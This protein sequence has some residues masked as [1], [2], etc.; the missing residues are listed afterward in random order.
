MRQPTSVL[1]KAKT[2]ITNQNSFL[3]L[4]WSKLFQ[5]C[6]KMCKIMARKLESTYKVTMF[7][8]L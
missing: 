7:V 4:G 5:M 1:T 3:P 8:C 6:I 2:I